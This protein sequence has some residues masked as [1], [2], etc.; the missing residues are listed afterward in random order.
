V[1]GFNRAQEVAALAT[2]KRTLS[3]DIAQYRSR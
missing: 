3:A 1:A 2:I